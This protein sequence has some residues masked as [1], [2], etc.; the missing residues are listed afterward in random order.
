MFFQ[1][2]GWQCP[3]CPLPRVATDVR[4]KFQTENVSKNEQERKK[5]IYF[6]PNS[7]SDEVDLQQIM[8]GL[9]DTS[10]RDY[11]TKRYYSLDCV[12]AFH[13]LLNDGGKTKSLNPGSSVLNPIIRPSTL[14]R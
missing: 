7:N 5:N 3:T 1:I 14:D 4:S 12:S 9:Y 10:G 2:V 8:L 6:V 11:S 13:C